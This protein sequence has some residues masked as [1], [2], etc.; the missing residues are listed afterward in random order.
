M[1][2]A[3]TRSP[4]FSF[5]SQLRFTNAAPAINTLEFDAGEGQGYRTVAWDQPL[6]VTYPADGTYTLRFRLSCAD[7]SVLL[8]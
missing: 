7:G 1:S 2:K 3:A 6:T 8:S 4:Q 5:P